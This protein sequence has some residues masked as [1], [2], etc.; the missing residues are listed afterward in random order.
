MLRGGLF[1]GDAGCWTRPHRCGIEHGFDVDCRVKEVLPHR[2]NGRERD[3]HPKEASM[4]P[5]G[6]SVR[7]GRVQ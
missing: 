3:R 4:I 5:H 1:W 6:T 2:V 7:P